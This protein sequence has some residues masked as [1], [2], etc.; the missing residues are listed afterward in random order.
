MLLFF[1]FIFFDFS[2]NFQ[3]KYSKFVRDLS[4]HLSFLSCPNCV[5]F[6]CRVL[7]IFFWNM[8]S[9][10]PPFVVRNSLANPFYQNIKV[11]ENFQ[12]FSDFQIV[13]TLLPVF[14]QFW[15][16]N[17]FFS[18]NISSYPSYFVVSNSLTNQFYQK[19]WG[20][21]TWK[22]SQNEIRKSILV[23]P[24]HMIFHV[25]LF[26]VIVTVIFVINRKKKRKTTSPPKLFTKVGTEY[27]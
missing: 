24:N 9:Y 21:W 4:I 5:I 3:K 14:V 18:L 19:Y 15:K 7:K 26:E 10:P 11:S 13:P 22:K 23:I 25:F 8:F 2:V 6:F 12:I 1:F 17:F 16:C 20:F 27:I